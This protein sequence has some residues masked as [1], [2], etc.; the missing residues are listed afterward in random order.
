MKKIIFR[1]PFIKI[2]KSRLFA[3]E[4]YIAEAKNDI[5][6]ANH[7][8]KIYFNGDWVLSLN[9]L[10]IAESYYGE[11]I[12]E[13]D[14]AARYMGFRNYEDM[15]EYSNLHYTSTIS[16]EI[17]RLNIPSFLF[18]KITLYYM[19]R[20]KIFKLFLEVLL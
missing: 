15:I 19:R 1:N 2:T 13:L 17:R 3:A 16:K 5:S 14:I 8:I 18:A 7:L 10:D 12:D 6:F 9:A 11:A 4:T 20:I